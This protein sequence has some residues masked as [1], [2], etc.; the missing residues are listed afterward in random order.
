M[1]FEHKLLVG[2]GEIKAIV[3]ECN[4]CHSRTVFLPGD[5]EVPPLKCPR[6]H[7]WDWNTPSE[8]RAFETSF[9]AFLW[10]VKRLRDSAR[11]N[12]GFTILL[13][14]EEPKREK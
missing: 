4:E 10:G 9:A 5:V 7:H 8:P 3:F 13:E 12:P 11:K 6:E 2:L 1:T 14:F